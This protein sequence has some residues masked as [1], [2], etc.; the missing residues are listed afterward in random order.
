[1]YFVIIAKQIIE[2]VY[3]SKLCGISEGLAYLHSQDPPV[4]HGDLHPV[5]LFHQFVLFSISLLR[6]W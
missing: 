6:F 3:F 4:I 1:M 5:R 2:A